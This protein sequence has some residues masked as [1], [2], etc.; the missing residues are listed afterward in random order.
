MSEL[1]GDASD[2]RKLYSAFHAL[3]TYYNIMRV[4]ERCQRAGIL[5]S[6]RAL[7]ELRGRLGFTARGYRLDVAMLDRDLYA[8]EGRACYERF[9]ADSARLQAERSHLPRFDWG[10]QGYLFDYATYAAHNSLA[11]G[12][13]DFAESR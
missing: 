8:S 9:K 6:P 7:H 11:Q 1:T 4:L 3:Y 13:E 5:R 2:P 10:G 12:R